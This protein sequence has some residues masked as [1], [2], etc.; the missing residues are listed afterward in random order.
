MLV[1]YAFL[2]FFEMALASL[3]PII[4]Y[5]RVPDGG[6]GLSS[7]QI[8]VVLAA[9]GAYNVL[10]QFFASPRLTDRLGAFRMQV[11]TQGAIPL[12]FVLFPVEN[13][14]ARVAGGFGGW[15][16]VVLVVHL[17]IMSLI[18]VG[19]GTSITYRVVNAF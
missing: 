16:K 11:I 4:L 14:L 15:V 17:M 10:F 8:G 13:A 9:W 5:T 1:V 6:L 12:I 19:Y 7:H 18:Y 2:C 3:L